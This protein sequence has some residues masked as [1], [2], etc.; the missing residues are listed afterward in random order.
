MYRKKHG[1]NR[2]QY[3]PLF[4]ASIE[5]LGTYPQS[6]NGDYCTTFC[7]TIVI[8]VRS[9]LLPSKRLWQRWHN[10]CVLSVAGLVN[11]EFAASGYLVTSAL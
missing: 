7:L 8:I 1:L 5:G 6:K 10:C 2:V 4:W 9:L 3:Y 11:Q